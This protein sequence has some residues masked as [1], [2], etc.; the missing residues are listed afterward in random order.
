MKGL[1]LLLTLIPSLL[2]A[3][4]ITYKP[5]LEDGKT[6]VYELH[7]VDLHFNFL[8]CESRDWI[9]GDT[10]I[11]GRRFYKMYSIEY[12]DEHPVPSLSLWYEEGGRAY[13]YDGSHLMYD[14]TLSTG[15]GMPSAFWGGYPEDCHVVKTDT[16]DVHGTCRK[17]ILWDGGWGENVWVEGIGC[18]GKLDEP[19]GHQVSDGKRYILL[20]CHVGDSCVF[21]KPDFEAPSVSPLLG[22]SS[23]VENHKVWTY[24]VDNPSSA[25]EYYR[26]W[27]E[28]YYLEEDTVIAGRESVKLY[29]DS[30]EPGNEHER[31]Y[32]GSLYEEGCKVYITYPGKDIP[33][34]LYDFPAVQQGDI[35]LATG[36]SCVIQ[37]RK[38]LMC[39]GRPLEVLYL[40]PCKERSFQ[41]PWLV[42][43]GSLRSDILDVNYWTPGGYRYVL[44][45][46]VVDGDTIYE[47]SKFDQTLRIAPSWQCPGNSTDYIYDLQGRRLSSP[48]SHGVYIQGGRKLVK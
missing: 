8:T 1:L 2:P 11:D 5:L 38:D 48:P 17:R 7:Y 42:G 19:L 35:V 26:E 36:I 10:I 45:S 33:E 16:I 20:S 44:E 47:K 15:D 31:L 28:R 27:H 34:V 43:V 30:D 46:C 39:E 6:W 21:E 41:F 25:P 40:S 14:F 13:G 23:F 4:D 29:V 18:P 37:G 9:D 32:I 3:Q 24:T 12:T 22:G